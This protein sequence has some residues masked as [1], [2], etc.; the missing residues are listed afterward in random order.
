M[1]QRVD[2]NVAVG[3]LLMIDGGSILSTARPK[4]L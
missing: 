3:E 4:R 1:Q 2:A